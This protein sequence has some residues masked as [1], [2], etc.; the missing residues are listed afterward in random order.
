MN[1][2]VHSVLP[3]DAAIRIDIHTEPKR[4][5]HQFVY[6]MTYEQFLERIPESVRMTIFKKRTP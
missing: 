5:N 3:N 4:A 6:K 2:L 1:D